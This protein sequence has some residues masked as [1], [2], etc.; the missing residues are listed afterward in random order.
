MHQSQARIVKG[1]RRRIREVL[2]RHGYDLL[3]DLAHVDHFYTQMARDLPQDAAVA[4]SN[5]THSFRFR[6]RKQR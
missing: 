1:R 4:A 2:L 5:N 3:V 6:V